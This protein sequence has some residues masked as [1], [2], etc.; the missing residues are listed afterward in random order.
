MLIKQKMIVKYIKR[1]KL[2]K[3]KLKNQKMQKINSLLKRFFFF[4]FVLNI[5]LL[6]LL[7]I[8]FFKFFFQKKKEV[9]KVGKIGRVMKNRYVRADEDKSEIG[10]YSNIS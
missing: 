4:F 8:F 6:L 9:R 7:L 3:K 1:K 2:K 10:K 5:H